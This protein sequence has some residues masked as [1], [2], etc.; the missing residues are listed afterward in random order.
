MF[1]HDSPASSHLDTPRTLVPLLG[2]LQPEAFLAFCRE[3]PGLKPSWHAYP[4]VGDSPTNPLATLARNGHLSLW[5]LPNHKPSWPSAGDSPAS[6][7]LGTQRKIVPLLGALQPQAFSALCRGL[8]GLKPSWHATDTCPSE[9]NI[10]FELLDFL[11]SCVALIRQPVF[12]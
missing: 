11:E 4:S 10:F 2:T 3:L 5:G 12:D 1:K 9:Q 7:H 8:P 6:S